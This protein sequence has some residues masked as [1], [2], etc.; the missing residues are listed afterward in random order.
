MS[1]KTQKSVR[2]IYMSDESA[3]RLKRI[4][5]KVEYKGLGEYKVSRND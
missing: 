2:Y 4:G 1:K 3:E 5:L